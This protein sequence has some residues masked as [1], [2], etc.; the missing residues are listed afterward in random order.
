MATLKSI[1]SIFAIGSR[2]RPTLG[3]ETARRLC[4][5][6]LADVPIAERESIMERLDRMVRS[7]DVSHLRSALFDVISH[8]RGETIARARIV[9]LDEK[10]KQ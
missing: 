9:A 8:A 7:A 6:L 4:A 5:E 2:R 1:S 10:L 3:V